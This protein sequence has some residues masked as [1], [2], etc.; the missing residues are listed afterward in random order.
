MIKVQID[1]Y[2]YLV[3]ET[4]ALHEESLEIIRGYISELNGLLVSSGG[5]H[6]DLISEKVKLLLQMFQEQLLVKIEHDFIE[7]ERQI[8]LF[9][10]R[11]NACDK[12][13][14]VKV[15]WEE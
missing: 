6:A 2:E 10:V 7:T 1:E 14:K 12:N 9:G 11:L 5:F 8:H 4:G 13:G 3:N 15:E